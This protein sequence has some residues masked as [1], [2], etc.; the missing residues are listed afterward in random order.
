M[1]GGVVGVVAGVST[2]GFAGVAA[3]VVTGGIVVNA[4]LVFEACIHTIVNF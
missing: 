3:G 2:V 4:E 1:A